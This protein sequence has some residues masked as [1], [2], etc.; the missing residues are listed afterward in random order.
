MPGQS[1]CGGDRATEQ[2]E[3]DETYNIKASAFIRRIL[4]PE[5]GSLEMERRVF[6]QLDLDVGRLVVLAICNPSHTIGH[7]DADSCSKV[8]VPAIS[9]FTRRKRASMVRRSRRTG[10]GKEGEGEG[11]LSK[12]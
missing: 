4:G 5:E 10:G 3:P 11:G 8:D 12:R 9:L 1:F 2:T 7:V 6:Y